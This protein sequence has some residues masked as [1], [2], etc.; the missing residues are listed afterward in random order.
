MICGGFFAS[1]SGFYF[2]VFCAF[3]GGL[4]CISLRVSG[5]NRD[6]GACD[7]WCSFWGSA[8][9]RGSGLVEG[10]EEQ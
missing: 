1:F 2:L 5:E 8:N 7:G 9:R 6:H 4:L 3:W 10:G